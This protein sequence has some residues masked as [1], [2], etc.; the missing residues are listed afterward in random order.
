MN[1]EL[2]EFRQQW[3]KEVKSNKHSQSEKGKVKTDDTGAGASYFGQ[4]NEDVDNRSDWDSVKEARNKPNTLG[5][6]VLA[7]NLLKEST[8]GE[9]SGETILFQLPGVQP[10]KKKCKIT[11]HETLPNK[12]KQSERFLDI[13][14]EDLVR[15]CHLISN[16]NNTCIDF[17]SKQT[18][19]DNIVKTIFSRVVHS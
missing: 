12:S 15:F 2:E 19:S 14:L 5:P 13:F 16:I 4:K 1:K 7:E 8:T 10:P 17:M 18:L 6:F 11:Q 9:N 3:K